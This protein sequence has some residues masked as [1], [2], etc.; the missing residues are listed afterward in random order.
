M[1]GTHA[2]GLRCTLTDH[3]EEGVEE[4][5]AV[6]V[7]CLALINRRVSEHHVPQDEHA[8]GRATPR[9]LVHLC[10]DGTEEEGGTCEERRDVPSFVEVRGAR[11]CDGLTVDAPGDGRHGDAFG[12]TVQADSFSGRVQLTG[13]LLDPVGGGWEQSATLVI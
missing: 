2:H 4:G 5:G 3:V 12:L 6:F 13:R 8:T 7:C 11:T 1:K 9:L 10:P